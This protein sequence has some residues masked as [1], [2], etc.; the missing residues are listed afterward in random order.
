MQFQREKKKK[1]IY[2][3]WFKPTKWLNHG[4]ITEKTAYSG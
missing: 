1:P 4:N 3:K 2:N